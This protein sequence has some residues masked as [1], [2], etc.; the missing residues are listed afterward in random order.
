MRR[1]LLLLVV[2]RRRVS[3]GVRRRRAG[4]RGQLQRRAAVDRRARVGVVL[5]LVEFS[6]DRTPGAWQRTLEEYKSKLT[7][8]LGFRVEDV[9]KKG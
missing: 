4:A 3:R 6:L 7:L 1:R 8:A 9:H 5:L 2:A